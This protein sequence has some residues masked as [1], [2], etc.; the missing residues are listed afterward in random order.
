MK[1][2]LYLYGEI[3]LFCFIDVKFCEFIFFN[4]IDI[5]VFVG[6]ILIVNIDF[7]YFYN[8]VFLSEVFFIFLILCLRFLVLSIVCCK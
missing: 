8:I 5:S 2:Y 6:V 7:Y 4:D 1:M 3:F